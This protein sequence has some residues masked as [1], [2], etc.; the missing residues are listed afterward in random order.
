MPDT[1]LIERWLP[2]AELG[3]ENTRE[4]C[5]L[6]VGQ[7]GGQGLKWCG[8]TLTEDL[9]LTLGLLFRALAP[10]RSRHNMRAVAEGIEAMRRR[11]RRGRIT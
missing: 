2:I 9:A 3:I 5:H 4:R 6:L 7:G 8:Y 1:R 11:L 10:M